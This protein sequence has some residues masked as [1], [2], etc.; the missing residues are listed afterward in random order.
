MAV[1]RCFL[2]NLKFLKNVYLIDCLSITFHAFI[3][4]LIISIKNIKLYINEL[5]L[6]G[7]EFFE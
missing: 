7:G 5:L 6:L 4:L 3:K 2:K 1:S